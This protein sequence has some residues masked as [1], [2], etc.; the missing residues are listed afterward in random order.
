[1]TPRRMYELGLMGLVIAS[2]VITFGLGLDDG[3]TGQLI[4][5]DGF[6]S[7]FFIPIVLILFLIGVVVFF[8]T[9]KKK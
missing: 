5:R 8:K 2:L 1:M 7:L 3:T 9:F 6:S 4:S